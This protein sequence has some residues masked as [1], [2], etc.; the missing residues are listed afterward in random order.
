M[1]P[2]LDWQMVS[3]GLAVVIAAG[4]LIVRMRRFFDGTVGGCGSCANCPQAESGR[5]ASS[6]RVIPLSSLTLPPE[7]CSASHPVQNVAPAQ[8]EKSTP[9]E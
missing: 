3:A 6:D 7:L 4:V 1:M 2:T 9:S 5:Q 8:S